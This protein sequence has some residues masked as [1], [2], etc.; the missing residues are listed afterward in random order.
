MNHKKIEIGE[1]AYLETYILNNSQ[2]YNVGKK[3]PLVLV[4][5]G[6]GYIFT[7]DR[8]AEPIALKFN[9]IGF[10]SAV[11][12]YTVGDKVKNVP[13]NGLIESAKAIK[14]IRENA[15]EWC[16]DTDMIIVCGFSAG[17]NLALQIATK[18]NEEW[19]SSELETTK[20]MLKV[21]LAI[22]A[23][24]A[25]NSNVFDENDKGFAASLVENPNTANERIFGSKNPSKEDIFNFD[26][27]NFIDEETPPMFIWHTY[28]DILTD[29]TNALNLSVELQKNKVPFE[30]H[31]FEKGEHGLALADRTTARKNSH[32]NSH[33][34]RWF[35]LCEEWISHY[36]DD[37]LPR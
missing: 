18:W 27:L 36:I 15:D 19:L 16:V 6:G 30:L 5:P 1:S 10:H 9:S 14:Y 23:Y 26:V 11:L 2:E 7:S 8:E 13:K 29:V 17:G 31:I 22:P 20:E 4:I 37:S 33:V 35:T 34:K 32:F 25:V 28:E 21:N 12:W 3:K 24:P